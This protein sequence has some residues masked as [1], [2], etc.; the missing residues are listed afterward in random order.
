[1]IKRNLRVQVPFFV[2]NFVL[3][4][5]K[6]MNQN[7]RK[8]YEGLKKKNF[9]P[10]N[11]CEVGVYLPEESNILGFIS[12]GIPAM[13]VE[14]D[15]DTAGKLREYFAGKQ[16]VK[17]IEA[18]VYDYSGEI[19]LS[20]KRASTFIS[21]LESSPALVN[22][23][24]KINEADQFTARC[25]K[26]G[27][28]DDGDIDLLSID[29]EGAEW[30]VLKHM[31]SRP[32]VISIET[33]GKYYTNPKILEIR[34]WMEENCYRE[35]Y[36]DASDTVYVRPEIIPVSFQDK[37]NFRFQNIKIWLKRQKRYLKSR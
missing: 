23:K 3:F 32:A 11:I 8:F 6:I 14:A 12:N 26:F 34:T 33:H 13:L 30:Y 36:K 31:E 7:A 17:I 25:I 1:M 35:W 9:S 20:R 29:I 5:D 24:Y 22:D 19:K 4:F 10:K 16:N 28:I 18:A 37:M 21:E 27:E 2:C 15:P